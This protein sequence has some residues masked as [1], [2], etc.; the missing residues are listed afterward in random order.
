[1]NSQF[2]N[3]DDGIYNPT[4]TEH[5]LAGNT[6]SADQVIGNRLKVLKPTIAYKGSPHSARRIHWPKG[7][8]TGE[9]YSWVYDDNGNLFWMFGE[10]VKGRTSIYVKHEPGRFKVVPSAGGSQ[11]LLSNDSGSSL[12]DIP[13]FDHL[14]RVFSKVLLIGGIGAGVYFLSPFFPEIRDGF[15]HVSNQ[16][17]KKL[18]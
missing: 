2:V 7:Y 14:D 15:Q 8:L 16:L 12:F 9:V 1:M 3:S 4:R 17:K 5:G 11:Y 13:S 10:P 18:S 6:L